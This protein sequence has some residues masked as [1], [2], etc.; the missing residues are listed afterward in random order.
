MKKYLKIVSVCLIL[1]IISVS[2]VLYYPIH[3]NSIN[4]SDGRLSYKYLKSVTVV[5]EGK[6]LIEKKYINEITNEEITDYKIMEW[7]GTGIIVK[8]TKDDIYIITNNH[9]AGNHPY[10]NIKYPVVYVLNNEKMETA[11]II[12]NHPDY[13]VA[14]IKIPNVLSDKRVIIGFNTAK[15]Q[16]K[17]YMVGTSLGDPYIYSEGCLAGKIDEFDLYQLPTMPGNSGS[18]VFNVKGEITGLIFAGRGINIL[19]QDIV[20]GIA[21]DSMIIKDFLIKEGVLL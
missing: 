11:E 18:G 19:L 21:I 4:L 3:K 5:I 10:I 15:I 1:T 20:Y 12:S 8:I 13:D 6:G 7:V 9:V 16:D 17:A 2:I 14:L